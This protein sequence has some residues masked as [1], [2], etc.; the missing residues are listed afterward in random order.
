LAGGRA[1]YEDRHIIVQI[2]DATASKAFLL[3]AVHKQSFAYGH[4]TDVYFKNGSAAETAQ[5]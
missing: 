2:A 1:V 4:F 5:K 3:L